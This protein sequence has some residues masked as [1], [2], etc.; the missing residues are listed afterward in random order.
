MEC[1]DGNFCL[2]DAGTNTAICV[3]LDKT[4][5]NRIGREALT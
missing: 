3:L 2:E 1:A 4:N 5:L